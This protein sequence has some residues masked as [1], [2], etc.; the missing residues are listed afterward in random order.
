MIWRRSL[1]IIIL[2]FE[3]L[4]ITAL[5]KSKN[6]GRGGGGEGRG[7]YIPFAKW[8]YCNPFYPLRLSFMINGSRS[9]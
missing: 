3:K 5:K 7:Y 9:G 1:K 4:L 2:I 6:G 8:D